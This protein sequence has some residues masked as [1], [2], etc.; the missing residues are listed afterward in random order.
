M[1]IRKFVLYGCLVFGLCS[2][3]VKAQAPVY[4]PGDI[5][6]VSVKFAGPDA[7]KISA[8]AMG[9]KRQNPTSNPSPFQDQF[10]A[11]NSRKTGPNTFEISFLVTK[12]QASGEYIITYISATVDLGNGAVGFSY[13]PGEFPAKTFKIE[14]STTVEKPMIKDVELP[15]T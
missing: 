5:I 13:L 10:D 9:L 8:V 14:N 1:R 4:K 6:H 3:P 11:R 12:S 7:E 2:V 15:K